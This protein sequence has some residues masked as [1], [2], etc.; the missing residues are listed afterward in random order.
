MANYI[1]IHMHIVPGVDDGARDMDES[2][3]EIRMSIRQGV[4]VI[5]TTPHSFAFD[6]DAP[7]VFQQ[8]ELLKK[9]AEEE[10]LQ[11]SLYLGCEVLMYP[12]TADE[13][14]RKL[15]Q[16]IYPTMN[17]TK[18]VLTE[19]DPYSFTQEDAEYCADQVI[20]AGYIPIIAHAE[21]YHFMTADGA[22]VLK[23]RGA[24]LQINAYSVIKEKKD[25]IRNVTGEMLS[26]RLVDFVG[27]DAHRISHRAPDIETGS[28]AIPQLYTEEYG[29]K[30]LTENALKLL[31]RGEE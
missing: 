2:L 28:L 7:R 12:E 26:R 17:E 3:E 20:K 16:G 13:C 23:N 25:R 19:F 21:R 14:I 1:D 30:I 31:I 6:Y 29:R 15:K 22:A 11:V 4:G 18:Y 10:G 24:L 27:T 5:I 8:F 9:R